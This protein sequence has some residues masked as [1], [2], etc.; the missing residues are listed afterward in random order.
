MGP[1]PFPGVERLLRIAL[2]CF[3][4]RRAHL[5]AWTNGPEGEKE[6]IERGHAPILRLW[7][8]VG[9]LLD[10]LHR[11]AHSCKQGERPNSPSSESGQ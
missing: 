5:G 11:G 10:G 1:A 9:N 8:N 3:S 4:R 6:A 2:H 7:E